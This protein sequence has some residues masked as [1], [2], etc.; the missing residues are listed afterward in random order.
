MIRRIMVDCGVPFDSSTFSY[1]LAVS[2]DRDA[3][4]ISKIISMMFEKKI[5]FEQLFQKTVFTKV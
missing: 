5:T 1:L 2:K 4:F 3:K